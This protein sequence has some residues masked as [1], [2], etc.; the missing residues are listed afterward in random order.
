MTAVPRL[1]RIFKAR[2]RAGEEAAYERFL[3]T[4]TLPYLRSQK[5]MLEVLVGRNHEHGHH[6]VVIVTLWASEAA[7]RA[8]AGGDWE[9]GVIDPA[10][11]APLLEDSTCTHYEVTSP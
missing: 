7:L 2:P 9:E 5:G 6:E 3:R 11:E 10:R 1:L 8:A 4:S